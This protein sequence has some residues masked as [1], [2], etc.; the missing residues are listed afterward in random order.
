MHSFKINGS[1]FEKVSKIKYF[2]GFLPNLQK[3]NKST[4]DVA[5]NDDL[6]SFEAY[7]DERF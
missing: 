3:V 4:A 6:L 7:G 1:R 2:S 5:K